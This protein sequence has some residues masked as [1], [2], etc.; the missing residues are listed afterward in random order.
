MIDAFFLTT[1]CKQML[2]MPFEFEEKSIITVMNPNAM[3]AHAIATN[4]V[5]FF[6]NIEV[7]FMFALSFDSLRSTT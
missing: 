2:K 1:N 6:K 4:F 5:T 7:D 3:P